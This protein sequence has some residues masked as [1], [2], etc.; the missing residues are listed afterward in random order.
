MQAIEAA[1][2]RENGPL[3][4]SLNEMRETKAALLAKELNAALERLRKL[5]DEAAELREGVQQAYF[6]RI[7]QRWPRCWATALTATA[8]CRK[9]HMMAE[10]SDVDEEAA[11]LRTHIDHFRTHAG[12]RRRDWEEARFP[13]AGD[14]PRSEHTAVEDRRHR[15]KRAA[16]YRAWA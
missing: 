12:G 7:S 14:E 11:R 9:P 1:A 2:L 10:R 8:C 5:V 4:D 15:R 16:D 6:E 13:D 3:I